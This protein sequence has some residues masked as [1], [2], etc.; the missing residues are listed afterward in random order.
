M[1]NYEL[2]HEVEIVMEQEDDEELEFWEED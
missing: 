1:E 2:L